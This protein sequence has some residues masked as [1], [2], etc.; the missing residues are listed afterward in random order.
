MHRATL[1]QVSLL[2]P[3]LPWPPPAKASR[4]RATVPLIADPNHPVIAAR[5]A[6]DRGDVDSLVALLAD[7]DQLAR[8]A[9]AQN[10]GDLGDP[11]AVGPLIRCLQAADPGLQISALKALA[12]IG[13]PTVTEEVFDVASGDAPF[14]VRAEAAATLGSLGDARAAKLIGAML[15]EPDNPYPRGTRKWAT[16]L[17]VELNGTDAIADLLAARSGAGV[18]GRWRLWRAIRSLNRSRDRP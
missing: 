3:D 8:W 16:K 6:R 13:D 17:L 11:R 18:V 1:G 10:L 14:G 15:R 5:N 4:P 9:A 7:T 12:R 2:P